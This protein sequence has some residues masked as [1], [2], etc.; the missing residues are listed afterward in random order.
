LVSRRLGFSRHA[1]ADIRALAAHDRRTADRIGA[2][3]INYVENDQGD[4]LKLAGGSGLYR[5]RVGDWRV[6]LTLD[7]GG[8]IVSIAR[9]VNRCDAYRG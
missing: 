4:I 3:I 2:A 9:I 1:R 8:Q 5:L 7:D 6:L